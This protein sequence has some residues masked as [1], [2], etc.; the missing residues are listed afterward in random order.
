MPSRE[1]SPEFEGKVIN[2]S[3]DVVV[4]QRTGI[5][6]YVVRLLLPPGAAQTLAANKIALIP[7]I[8][9]EVFIATDKRTVLSYLVKP[10]A[11]Q[12]MHT[13]RER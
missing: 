4:D 12:I 5:G 11:D 10:L 3:P 13:F 7:G 1:N 6:H 9:V 8:P 2:I